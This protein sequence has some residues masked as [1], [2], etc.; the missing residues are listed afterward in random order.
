MI[1]YNVSIYLNFLQEG[2]Y[3]GRRHELLKQRND[4]VIRSCLIPL[5]EKEIND[6]DFPLI[7]KEVHNLLFSKYTQAN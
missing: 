3:P 4:K 6:E 7:E 5:D 1:I 2:Y